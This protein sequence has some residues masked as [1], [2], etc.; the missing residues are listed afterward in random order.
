[1]A[2]VS[3]IGFLLVATTLLVFYRVY[4]QDFVYVDDP[5]WVMRNPYVLA[6]LDRQSVSW[7]F[8]ADSAKASANWCPLTWLSL[9]LDTSLYGVSAGGYKLTNL[10][11]HVSTVLLLFFALNQ[12]TGDATRSGFAAALFAIHPLHVESVVWVAERKGVLSTFFGVAALWAYSKY[13]RSFSRT[14]YAVTLAAFLCSL[15]SKQTLVTLPFMLLLLDVWPLKRLSTDAL[16]RKTASPKGA[17]AA[18]SQSDGVGSTTVQSAF[19]GRP[20][21]E[22]L[23]LFLL[24]VLFSVVAFAAQRHGESVVSLETLSFTDRCANAVVSYATYLRRTFWPLDLAVVYPHPQDGYSLL[25]VAAAGLLLLL[26]TLIAWTQRK[27]RPH[28]FVGWFWF[29]G[30]LVPMIGLVQLGSTQVADRYT[31]IPLIGLF[32]AICWSALPRSRWN[33]LT[34]IVGASAVLVLAVIAWR[35]TGFWRNSETLYAHAIAVTQRNRIAHDQLG[36]VYAE[37]GRSAEATQQFHKSLTIDPLAASPNNNLGALLLQEGKPDEAL[38]H[39]ETALRTDPLNVDAHMNAAY[40]LFLQSHFRAAAEHLEAVL[41]V[42]PNH[43]MA[44]YHLGLVS[45]QHLNQAEEA[46]GHFQQVLDSR[47]QRTSAQNNRRVVAKSANFLGRLAHD[48]G[49]L[50][51]AVAFFQQAVRLEPRLAEAHNNMGVTLMAM[52]RRNEAIRSFQ[53]SLAVQPSFQNAEQNLRRA[54]QE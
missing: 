9:M 47:D 27:D 54:L 1:M 43:V 16:G 36:A 14:W 30:T 50:D 12:L 49:Q 13:A 28:L 39:F 31:Q 34:P 41:R 33:R 37:Q 6:G 2:R 10:G 22:K 18:T 8:S 19:F 26:L 40:A 5:T 52:G 3:L 46:A 38:P 17:Q 48:V 25:T 29:L 23:P 53:Q 20:I 7:A 21:L 4:D 24:T 45:L 32:I 35:Q 11:L 44:H 51:R 15:A 42:D